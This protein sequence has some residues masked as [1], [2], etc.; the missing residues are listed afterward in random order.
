MDDVSVSERKIT[1]GARRLLTHIQKLGLNINSW[2]EKNDLNRIQIQ[3]VI[4]GERWKRASVDF[5]VAIC[6]AV[7]AEGGTIHV[8]QFASATARS[9]KRRAA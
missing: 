1:E 2:C 6:R 5:A 9:P 8:E 4:N 7:R 3:R